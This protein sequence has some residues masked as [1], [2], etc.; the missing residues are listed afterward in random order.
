[1]L[2]RSQAATSSS[3]RQPRRDCAVTAGASSAAGRQPDDG[4]AGAAAGRAGRRDVR[5]GSGPRSS[6]RSL[7][8]LTL[9]FFFLPP[10]GTFTI[11]D[12]QNWI[13]LFAFLVVAVI[14]SN[15]SAAAQERAREAIARRNEVTRLFDLT[16]DVLL[17]T[18]T[19]GAIDALARH[20]AR[21]FELAASR[22]LPAG[23]SR[24]AHPPGRQR[25]R[26]DR[27]GHAEHGARQ[28]ARHA[29]V[30]RPSA[31]LRRPRA[32]RRRA[33]SV[34]DRAAAPRHEG[35]RPAGRRRRRPSTSARS[36]RWPASSR[37]RS[38]GRSS[39][40]SATPRSWCGRRRTWRRRCSRRSA[41][42][43][44]RRS[45]RSASPSRTCAATCRPRS[46]ARRPARPSP[47]STG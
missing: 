47:S 37:L 7:A 2:R 6:C 25:G 23:R 18:E 35:G 27:R 14:A 11:A 39:W 30:R 43:C 31:R 8:M 44:G 33:T 24:L 15:L 20:V 5:R 22:D 19:A 10:V 36:T 40:A 21:R 12:P 17:T 4:R 38:S 29:G 45:P 9:N 46:A 3:S 1:M 32:G 26:R 34:L 28:G 41:T 13:A 16:R 42:T